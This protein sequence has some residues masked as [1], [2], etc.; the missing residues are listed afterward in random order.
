MFSQCMTVRTPACLAIL[1][2]CFA[3]GVHA[4]F[5]EVTIGPEDL[6][7]VT[8]EGQPDLTGQYAVESN[9][10]VLFPL[11]GRVEAE[12]LT[13]HGLTGVLEGRLDAYISDPKVSVDVRPPQRVFVFGEVR[14]P[15][16]YDLT[17][18]MTVLELLLEAEYSGVSEVLVVRTGNVR[19]PVLPEQARPSDVIRVNLRQL[20]SDLQ[21]G[22]LSR[23][24]RLETG[25]T[26][27]VPIL[28]PSTVFVGGEVNSPGAYS[29]A[30]GTTVLQMLTLA[31]WVTRQ[32]S[33]E[34]VRVVRFE[35]GER[36]ER[37]ADLDAIVRP[38]DTIVVPEAFFNPSFTSAQG[39]LALSVGEIRVGRY[40]AI[41]PALPLTELGVDSRLV[42]TDGNRQSDLLV[43]LT[44]E[45]E[46]GLDLR[47]V[48]VF[49]NLS[50][51]LQYY[52]SFESERAVNPGYDVSMEFDLA[53]RVV[54]T[55]GYSFLS[56][57]DRFPLRPG[58]AVPP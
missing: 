16:F 52:Q 33:P 2:L 13:A 48:R 3:G 50:A 20:E 28:D 14:Q 21:H 55:G 22:D 46:V 29:V 7:M 8:V 10:S 6:V 25:D 30:D 36:V 19:A 56:T 5:S 32:A 51:G 4:Q 57:R 17:E 37:R 47:R 45:F 34:R 12:G 41:T 26:V 58:R 40:L 39:G 9:G 15:G 54:F 43:E 53:R 38:G 18:G 24:L 1:V 31:G 35:D 42:D 49:G 44:P 27:F 11:I 23:N